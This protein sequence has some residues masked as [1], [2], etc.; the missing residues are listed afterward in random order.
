M[1]NPAA[2]Y[3]S[4]MVPTLFGP[5]A[6]KLVHAADPKAHERILDVGCGTGIENHVVIEFH[7]NIVRAWPS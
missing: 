3:E 1:S 4:Y 5:W 2:G 7:A 6:T